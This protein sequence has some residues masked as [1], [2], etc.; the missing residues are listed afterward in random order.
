MNLHGLI[1]K[2]LVTLRAKQNFANKPKSVKVEYDPDKEMLKI[3]SRIRSSSSL[4]T[5]LVKLEID[6]ISYSM[7]RDRVHRFRFRDRKLGFIFLNEINETNEIRVRCSCP[8]DYFMWQ[9]PNKLKGSLLGR[10][11]PYVPVPGSNRPPRNPDNV[12]GVCK[13]TLR[14]IE[15]L[16]KQ[17][18]VKLKPETKDYV[19]NAFK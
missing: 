3:E 11:K 12:N 7:V 13:H 1:N 6:G 8:D 2:G 16:V 14:V 5:Y 19:D 4:S 18:I 17:R 9:Y 10:F 15:W